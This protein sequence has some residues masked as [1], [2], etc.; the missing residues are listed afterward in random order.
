F[1]LTTKREYTC[2]VDRNLI[3]GAS[4]HA[5]TPYGFAH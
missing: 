2:H 3:I 5:L 1:Y 4:P